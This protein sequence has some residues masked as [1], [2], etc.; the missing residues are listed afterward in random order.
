MY[1]LLH[2]FALTGWQHSIKTDKKG[3]NGLHLLQA[4]L[5]LCADLL[6]VRKLQRSKALIWLTPFTAQQQQPAGP[7]CHCHFLCWPC[8]LRHPLHALPLLHCLSHHDSS[9]CTAVSCW[10]MTHAGSCEGT[11]CC[12]AA[13]TTQTTH[14]VG[15]QHQLSRTGKS[16]VFVLSYALVPRS[17]QSSK[18][19]QYCCKHARRLW[20]R[21]YNNFSKCQQVQST[22]KRLSQ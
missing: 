11:C 17:T 6:S 10:E 8:E 15:E 16:A 22:Q 20:C 3:H 7:L 19:Q 13:S 18:S 9:H 2:Q 4:V 21:L 12:L 5:A 1:C 14:R